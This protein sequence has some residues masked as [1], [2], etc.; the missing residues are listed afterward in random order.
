MP[1]KV[2]TESE[3]KALQKISLDML[4]FFDNFCKKNNLTY[5]L[6]GGGCIGAV[7]SGG[8]I[9]WDDDID[10]FMLRPD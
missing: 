3:T 1:N 4:L 6:C 7:R 9:P 5:F 2:L 8:F 10:V